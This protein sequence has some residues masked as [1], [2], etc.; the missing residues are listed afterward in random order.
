MNIFSKLLKEATDEL[1]LP[2]D[3]TAVPAG[4]EPKEEPKKEEEPKEEEPKEGEDEEAEEGTIQAKLQ[5]IIMSILDAIEQESLADGNPIED[6]ESADVGLEL[7]HKMA[8]KL[9][10]ED[11]QMAYDTLAEYF[12][13]SVD[14]EAPEPAEDE[15]FE[16][17]AEAPAEDAYA[18][19][20]VKTESL[21][22]K[23]KGSLKK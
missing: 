14:E 9:S 13:M 18:E 3:E 12:D 6:D 7:L 19:E 17:P 16:P 5:D 22:K 15:F 4:E 2:V 8:T 20:E 1:D 10:D 21:K 23:S 11:A